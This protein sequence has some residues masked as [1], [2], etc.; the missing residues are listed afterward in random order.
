MKF[1]TNHTITENFQILTK[2]TTTAT[3]HNQQA[4]IYFVGLIALLF[5]LWCWLFPY[6]GISSN[7][8][9]LLDMIIVTGMCIF[10]NLKFSTH[11]L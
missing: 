10:Y 8:K 7:K 6:L 9:R 11:K 5:V 3:D 2:T 1:L 4:I